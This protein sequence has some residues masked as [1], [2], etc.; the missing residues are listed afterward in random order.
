MVKTTWSSSRSTAITIPGEK[1]T[2][3]RMQLSIQVF[4]SVC[5]GDGQ[6]TTMLKL[7]ELEQESEAAAGRF[8]FRAQR[9]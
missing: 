7:E 2:E 1:R 9:Y 5:I 6:P 3:S 4:M 8:Q